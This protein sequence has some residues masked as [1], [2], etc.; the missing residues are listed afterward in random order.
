MGRRITRADPEERARL[1]G[2]PL[3]RGVNRRKFLR[4]ARERMG[5]RGPTATSAVRAIVWAMT[6]GRCYY[7]GLQTNPFENFC[8][9][10]VQ[11]LSRGGTNDIDNLVPC[12]DYCNR[13]KGTHLVEEW[14]VLRRV[15]YCAQFYDEELLYIDCGLPGA[16]PEPPPLWFQTEEF[17]A[18]EYDQMRHNVLQACR[19]EPHLGD[20]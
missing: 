17:T 14:Q 15:Q 8:V 1:M 9:D 11:P 19:T 13:Y 20:Y 2:D 7:C 4:N 10:H 5:Q 18:L 16:D 3:I 12:C 6:N